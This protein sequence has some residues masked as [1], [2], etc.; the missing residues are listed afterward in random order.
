M[1][2]IIMCRRV[3]VIARAAVTVA[4]VFQRRAAL[5]EM[6][7]PM[8][9]Q[10]NIHG[11][12]GKYGHNRPSRYHGGSVG[13]SRPVIRQY[14][15]RLNVPKD[16]TTSETVEHTR[17]LPVFEQHPAFRVDA[18]D[19]YVGRESKMSEQGRHLSSLATHSAPSCHSHCGAHEAGQ[20][21]ATVVCG[22]CFAFDSLQP[23]ASP[24]PVGVRRHD[25]M[26][27]LRDS[28]QWHMPCRGVYDL[29]LMFQAVLAKS[30]LRFHAMVFIFETLCC[31]P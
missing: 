31:S 3:M 14:P 19:L 2:T 21:I 18:M 25:T 23:I 8:M 4:L 24:L 5:S 20:R 10:S 15:D 27:S 28:V 1:I 26:G 7:G 16:V 13:Y 30:A 11:G 6:S 12:P 29:L 9:G 17:W 22:S